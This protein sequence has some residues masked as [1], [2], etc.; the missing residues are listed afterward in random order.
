MRS[1]LIGPMQG[2]L[3]SS[4]Y[5][6]S[7]TPRVSRKLGYLRLF[8]FVLSMLF[9][10][11][12]YGQMIVDCS[13]SDP[14]AYP[15]IN[16]A[17]ANV[18]GPGATILVSGT[19][20]ED[21]AMYSVHNLNLGAFWGQTATVRGNISV[22]ESDVVYL[23]GLNVLGATNDGFTINGS[24]GVTLDSCAS[25]GNYG[26]GLRASNLSEITL[27]GPGWFD[28]NGP[29]GITI[30]GNSILT[31]GASVGPVD[32]SGNKG[33]GIWMSQGSISI[34][35]G[36]TTITNN[37]NNLSSGVAF[38]GYG[39]VMYGGSTAQ[40]GT[41]AG[42]NLIEGNES[43]GIF[44]EENSE[45]SLWVCGTSPF[46]SLIERNGPVGLTAGFGSQ[47]TLASN[48]QIIGHTGPGIDLFGHSQLNASG[49]NLIS[50]NGTAGDPRSAGIRVDGN[51]EVFLRGGQISRN[52]GPG[53]LALVN[54]SAD[55][56]GVS[57]SGN[58]AGIISC[59]SS[60]F[61]VSDLAGP[62][63]YSAGLVCRTPHNLG[64][65][66]Y[67]PIQPT[68]PDWTLQK[69]RQAQYQKLATKKS[70]QF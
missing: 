37:T 52:A 14:T 33:P 69:K 38:P 61:M 65:R 13:L 64:N 2:E 25:N 39:L 46:Q 47:V 30:T 48:V 53:I 59:D 19:C 32:I 54:S 12:A 70:H 10:T 57:F 67:V 60:S 40:I 43:G 26:W 34:W 22:N 62:N 18:S 42:G 24:R 35:S 50:Q 28:G 29:G 9:A 56:T 49:P 23:Y 21:V 3:S 68:A 7:T 8:I 15:T 44:V 6:G 4:G 55:F 5:Q 27:V 45:I 16:A 31:I 20:V 63:G 58:S 51:S 1:S 41:C 36:N 17:L 11:T 66:H